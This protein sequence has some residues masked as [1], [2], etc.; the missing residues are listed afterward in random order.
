MVLTFDTFKLEL[1]DLIDFI[2]WNIKGYTTSGCKD[3]GIESSEFVTIELNSFLV[4]GFIQCYLQ[5]MRLY[6]VVFDFYHNK[7]V[8][9]NLF[10]KTQPKSNI[11]PNKSTRPT[12]LLVRRLY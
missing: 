6:S 8:I 11:F 1:F 9:F 10:L 12:F 4:L 2:G 3:I 5:R 7:W